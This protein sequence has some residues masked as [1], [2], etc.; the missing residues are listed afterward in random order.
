MLPIKTRELL[1]LLANDGTS[2]VIDGCVYHPELIEVS[3]I[4][5]NLSVSDSELETHLNILQN[6]GQ[7][8]LYGRLY[9]KVKKKFK[10]KRAHIE[11]QIIKFSEETGLHVYIVIMKTKPKNFNY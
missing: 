10:K 11:K 3:D 4:L 5:K 6:M 1:F 2:T 9:D 8:R 7:L